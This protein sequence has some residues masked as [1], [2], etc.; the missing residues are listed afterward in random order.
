M[1]LL[2]SRPFEPMQFTGMRRIKRKKFIFTDAFYQ[3]IKNMNIYNGDNKRQQR[4]KLK[5]C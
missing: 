3:Y 2:D 5:W 4:I 1:C